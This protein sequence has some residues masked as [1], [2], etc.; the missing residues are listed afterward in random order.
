MDVQ[1]EYS[2]FFSLHALD[3][4]PC[5]FPGADLA[6]PW[7]AGLEPVKKSALSRTL[8]HSSSMIL[9]P[10]PADKDASYTQL[11]KCYPMQYVTQQNQLE[12]TIWGRALKE[13]EAFRAQQQK[14]LT[15]AAQETV[16]VPSAQ[17]E[18]VPQITRVSKRKQLAQAYGFPLPPDRKHRVCKQNNNS[19]SSGKPTFRLLYPE[20]SELYQHTVV[21]RGLQK[22]NSDDQHT[23][24]TLNRFLMART[25]LSPML[26][27]FYFDAISTLIS[28]LWHDEVGSM[29]CR[30]YT[31]LE[32]FQHYSQQFEL[33]RSYIAPFVPAPQRR[34]AE[35]IKM[36]T[37]FRGKAPLVLAACIE[38]VKNPDAPL[39]QQTTEKL[40]LLLQALQDAGVAADM[41]R[42]KLMAWLASPEVA[43]H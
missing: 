10:A 5:D 41:Y 21:W 38:K 20:E 14:G 2:N 25:T 40:R 9:A 30:Y 6:R 19:G 42:R 15:D 22:V 17:L 37:V 16:A 35:R 32:C 27:V 39:P 36:K 7:P 43:T 34:N 26:Q 24:P 1:L 28:I 31:L 8:V 29:L 33:G 23:K 13:E 12:D 3:R 18:A 4:A 11:E